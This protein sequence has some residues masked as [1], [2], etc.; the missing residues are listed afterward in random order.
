MPPV[1]EV[2]EYEEPIGETRSSFD[3]LIDEFL[4][5]GSQETKQVEPMQPSTQ[6]DDI[7]T[8]TPGNRII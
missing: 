3:D 7:E 6:Y 2:D 4:G 1:D 8:F 5:T